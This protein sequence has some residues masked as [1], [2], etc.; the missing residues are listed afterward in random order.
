MIRTSTNDILS[1]F[2]SNLKDSGFRIMY[3]EGI[4]T[5]IYFEKNGNV[6]YCQANS[7]SDLSFSTVNK[8]RKNIGHGTRVADNICEPTIDH[9]TNTFRGTIDSEPYGSLEEIRDCKSNKSFNYQ[10]WD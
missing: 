9:A 2:A 10:I 6:G 3:P 1:K 5:W 8:Y 4:N 7:R